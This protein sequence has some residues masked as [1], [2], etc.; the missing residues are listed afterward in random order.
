M[1]L[2]KSLLLPAKRP[3]LW[4]LV[5]VDAKLQKAFFVRNW[6]DHDSTV[7]ERDEASIEKEVRLWC[8]HQAIA[9]THAFA[10]G[11]MTPRLDVAGDKVDWICHAS[12]TAGL[13]NPGN[14]LPK[15]A[16]PAS[17]LDQAFTLRRV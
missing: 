11:R 9:P 3:N 13:L 1:E 17:S 15:D 4:G 16:L 2:E 10:V 5:R 8:Q 7:A 6:R 12:D 14:I